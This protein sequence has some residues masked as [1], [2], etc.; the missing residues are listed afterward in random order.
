MSEPLWVGEDRA[1][2]I[3]DAVLIEAGGATGIRDIELLR[4]AL[5]RPRDKYVNGVIDLAALA[6]AY[7]FGLAKNQA[8]V[9][10]N[11]RT[12]FL[13]ASFFLAKNGVGFEPNEAQAVLVIEGLADGRVS[14]AE[15][16]EWI[17][18]SV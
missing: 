15:L 13:V 3:H 8:F 2:A 4:S 14:E 12:A 7:A 6:A 10:G 17:A 16:A 5:D 18:A 11:K 9:D 1:L